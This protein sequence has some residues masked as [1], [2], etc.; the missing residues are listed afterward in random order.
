MSKEKNKDELV[1]FLNL[2]NQ[3]D[4][5]NNTGEYIAQYLSKFTEDLKKCSSPYDAYCLLVAV[6]TFKKLATSIV[7][8]DPSL[9]S[10]FE[11]IANIICEQVKLFKFED[12]VDIN[13]ININ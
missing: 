6:L 9:T 10:D 7:P 1:D 13:N 2:E 4:I 3:E 8:V 12:D 5:I 11:D